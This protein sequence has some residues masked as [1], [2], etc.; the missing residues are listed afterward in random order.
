MKSLVVAEEEAAVCESKAIS[1]E[2]G[3]DLE[4]CWTPNQ[5]GE[6]G[7]RI[8]NDRALQYY[9]NFN[10][11]RH[12]HHLYGWCSFDVYIS[13]RAWKKL[14]DQSWILILHQ[15][16]F[17]RPLTSII[18]RLVRYKTWENETEAWRAAEHHVMKWYTRLFKAQLHHLAVLI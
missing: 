7:P 4:E 9:C 11:I 1:E 13:R 6:L 16:S 14:R 15:P 8:A 5:I 3:V 10:N 12:L 17:A 18:K 2:R